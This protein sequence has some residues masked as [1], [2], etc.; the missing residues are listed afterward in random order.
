VTVS[1]ALFLVADLAVA[2]GVEVLASAVLVTFAVVAVNVVVIDVAA[3]FCV[4]MT[5]CCDLSN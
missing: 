4:Q 5:P 2:S 1:V 3:V